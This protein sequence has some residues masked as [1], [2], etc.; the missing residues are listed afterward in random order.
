M[1]LAHFGGPTNIRC[2]K[3]Y[4]IIKHEEACFHDDLLEIFCKKCDMIKKRKEKLNKIKCSILINQLDL[5][6]R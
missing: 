6:I 4:D 5:G 2:D 1:P 3:C